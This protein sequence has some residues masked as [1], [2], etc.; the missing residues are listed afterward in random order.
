MVHTKTRRRVQVLSGQFHE[1]VISSRESVVQWNA[2]SGS[3]LPRRARTRVSRSLDIALRAA[4]RRRVQPD[5]AASPASG[6]NAVISSQHARDV[7]RGS[8]T[9]PFSP[10][11]SFGASNWGLISATKRRSGRE[12]AERRGEHGLQRNKRHVRRTEIRAARGNPPAQKARVR[13]LHRRPRASS[14]RRR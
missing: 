1:F 8:R 9:T 2:F 6:T 13:A 14:R 4:D 3:A 10:T 7:P 12:H 11:S 5:R